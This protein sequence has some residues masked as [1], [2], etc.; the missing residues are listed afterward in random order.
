MSPLA[1][2]IATTLALS[3]VIVMC[4]LMIRERFINDDCEHES[5]TEETSG[6]KP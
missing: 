1:F 5:G 2:N 4:I 3:P 6:S